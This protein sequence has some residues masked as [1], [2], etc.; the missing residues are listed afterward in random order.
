MDEY[1]GF[2]DRDYVLYVSLE[3]QSPSLGHLAITSPGEKGG[4]LDTV[5]LWDTGEPE[6]HVHVKRRDAA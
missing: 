2:Y 6:R 5:L 1:D 4:V 3:V